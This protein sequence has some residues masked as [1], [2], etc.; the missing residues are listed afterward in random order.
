MPEIHF[1]ERLF[2]VAS[3]LYQ[4]VLIIHFSLRKWRFAA[5]MRYGP[6]VYALGI[7]AAVISLLI[8]LDG[9]PWSLWLSGFLYLVWGIY[10][11]WIEYV[12]KIEWRSPIRWTIFIPYILLYL[13]TTM[14]YWFPLALIWKPLWYIYAVLF[15]IATYLNVSSHKR[16]AGRDN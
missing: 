11:Y 13:A 5:A 1:F 2:V 10:G 7:P 15:I 8:L 12:R 9:R 14:F 6:M 16:P 3:F 4:V